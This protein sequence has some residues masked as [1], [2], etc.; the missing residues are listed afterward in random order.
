MLAESVSLRPLVQ[1]EL[2]RL[3]LCETLRRAP[4]HLRLL[5]YLVE[6]R[7]ADE[8][9]AL[10]ETSIALEVFRRD[11]TTY[12]PQIDPIVRVTTGRLRARLDAHYTRADA[13]RRLRIKLPK[14]GYAPDFVL[15]SA[16]PASSAADSSRALE[17]VPMRNVT[18]NAS[19]DPACASLTDDLVEQLTRLPDVRVLAPRSQNRSRRG[20]EPG[21]SPL[22]AA[23]VIEGTL[24]SHEQSLMFT[25]GLLDA[26][27]RRRVWTK[28]LHGN[29]ASM[30]TLRRRVLDC[31]LGEAVP[32]VCSPFS[33][34]ATHS[35]PR[36]S[37]DQAPNL[38]ERARYLL[39]QRDPGQAELA[40]RLAERATQQAP[41]LSAAWS[42]LA[43]CRF[44]Q[45]G[46]MATE[47]G[48]AMATIRLE[49]QTALRLDGDNAE[50]LAFLATMEHLQRFDFASALSMYER[51]VRIEPANAMVRTRFCGSLM[52][53]GRFEEAGE[54]MTM[55]RRL[56]PLNLWLRMS[57]ALLYAYA[58]NHE[59][60][61][62]G[63]HDVLE[64]RPN[65]CFAFVM[66]A[67]NELWANDNGDIDRAQRYIDRACALMPE[68]PTHVM[69]VAMI[70]AARGQHS[71][72]RE[73]MDRTLAEFKD[74]YV[75]PIQ[76]AMAFGAL[77]DRE[78]VMRELRRAHETSDV[79][80]AEVCVDPFYEWLRAD[81]EF[82]G[83]LRGLG[84]PGWVGRC[85]DG[86]GSGLSSRIQHEMALPASD[87]VR[88]R[89]R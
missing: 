57:E 50:A 4:T 56:D 82:D 71:R 12:D 43:A 40:L 19:W 67:M 59:Q 5:R 81:A 26:A 6:K 77:R 42:T 52:Y 21:D 23:W 53:A 46:S 80:M 69:C 17:V 20:S 86:P 11:P 73:R 8:P 44:Q 27:T 58:R 36:P 79:L 66:G 9:A 89:D 70:D 74:A 18:G 1:E 49:T 68:N 3:A 65:H 2:A 60:A 51:A 48:V 16:V 62:A 85:I 63:F 39:L 75:S 22:S 64:L 34:S 38:V 78:G 33:S 47:P 14:G 10:C 88:S 61:R 30:D 15:E 84:L 7:L 29:P 45:L 72:A 83:F 35:S 32:L 28:T 13:R 24:R 41:S 87:G 76:A 31:C 54:M 25:L 37:E 55:A